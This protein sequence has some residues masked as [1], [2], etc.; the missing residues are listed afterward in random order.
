MQD[1]SDIRKYHLKNLQLFL[2]TNLLKEFCSWEKLHTDSCPVGTLLLQTPCHC[3]QEPVPPQNAYRNDWKKLPYYRLSL[4][5]KCGHFHTLQCYISL[6]FFS[7][8]SGHLSTSSK[9]L[10]LTHILGVKMKISCLWLDLFLVHEATLETYCLH[11]YI[12][13]HKFR[14]KTIF[15][16]LYPAIGTLAITDTK[17]PP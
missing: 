14:D 9:I 1:T 2:F 17:S 4:L 5:Q 10:S 13:F 6:V 3:G 16:L 12:S 8:Y 7:F 15:S 11:S